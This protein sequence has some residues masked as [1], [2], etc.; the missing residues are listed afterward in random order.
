MAMNFK[1]KLTSERAKKTYLLLAFFVL[2]FF[3]CNDFLLPWYVNR[4]MVIEVPLVIDKNF[5]EAKKS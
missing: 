4:G 2:L 3:V 5:N 1:K